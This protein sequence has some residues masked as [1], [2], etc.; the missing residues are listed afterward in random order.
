MR[1][2][3]SRQAN[4]TSARFEGLIFLRGPDCCSSYYCY[5]Y[6]CYCCCYHYR[7]QSPPRPP[8]PSSLGPLPHPQ[9]AGAH[10]R[11][12][13]AVLARVDGKKKKKNP[14]QCPAADSAEHVRACAHS[15]RG[16]GRITGISRTATGG[17]GS[18]THARRDE[19][20]GVIVGIAGWGWMGRCKACIGSPG[21][22]RLQEKR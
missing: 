5:Y 4:C 8:T 14:L 12:I 20:R 11:R 7:Y 15:Q 2:D 19:H 21:S 10:S 16:G 9:P 6:G 13:P 22:A 3:G 18:G 17:G 1:W